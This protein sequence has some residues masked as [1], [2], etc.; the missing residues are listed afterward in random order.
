MSTRSKLRKLLHRDK[1]HDEPQSPQSAAST[2]SPT[3]PFRYEIAPQGE[4]PRIGQR[5]LSGTG[6]QPVYT[7]ATVFKLMNPQGPV[8]PSLADA[9]PRK[10]LDRKSLDMQTLANASPTPNS[11]DRQAPVLPPVPSVDHSF[12]TPAVPQHNGDGV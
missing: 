11:R 5:P 9:R 12:D 6:R 4:S 7:I 3:Q 1:H 10:S 2:S 8:S